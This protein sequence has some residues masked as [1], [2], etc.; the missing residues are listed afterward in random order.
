M[1][2]IL[3]FSI[4]S[5]LFFTYKSLAQIQIIQ[6]KRNIPLSDE[7][8]VYKDYYI[9]GGAKEGLR[10][11]LVVP[12]TRWVNLRESNQAQDQS[13]K[14]LEP[15]G[16]LR[17]IFIQDHLSVARL[18]EGANYMSSP[19]LDQPGILMGDIVS[20]ERSFIPKALSKPPKDSSQVIEGVSQ[21]PSLNTLTN[22]SVSLNASRNNTST[23]TNLRLN[24]AP[25]ALPL[26]VK[27]VSVELSSSKTI[28]GGTN[29]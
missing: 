12:V 15:V 13:L 11:S 17:I 29:Q 1:K 24:E 14:I 22:S 4:F 5:I 9:A 28:D 2:R 18:Y 20:L 6:V 26:E 16:W 10:L 3:S 27:N 21:S 7:E 19:V 25:S 23:S 8:P